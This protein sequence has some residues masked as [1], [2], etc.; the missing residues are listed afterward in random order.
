MS[1]LLVFRPWPEDVERERIIIGAPMICACCGGSRLSKLGEDVT[2][3][4][5]EIPRGFVLAA[6]SW[7]P[8]WSSAAHATISSSC[9]SN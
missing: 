3:S 9:N 8:I 1:L 4:L 7:A 5:E 2:E 6:A